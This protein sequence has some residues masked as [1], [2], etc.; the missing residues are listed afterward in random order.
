VNRNGRTA[1]V[2]GWRFLRFAAVVPLVHGD[3]FD[4]NSGCVNLILAGPQPL[5]GNVA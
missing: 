3:I 1:G 2:T 4:P 5:Q